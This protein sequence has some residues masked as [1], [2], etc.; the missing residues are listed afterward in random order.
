[1][2]IQKITS[3]DISLLMPLFEKYVVFYQ[4]EF[5]FQKYHDYLKTVIDNQEAFVF[6]A[7]DENRKAV[8]FVLNYIT[9]SSLLAN[10]IMILNDLFVDSEIRKNGI[11]EQLIEASKSFAMEKNIKNI[12]L[13]TAKDN[14]VAQ[15]LYDKMNF[16]R[17]EQFFTYDLAL[18]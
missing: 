3:E 18:N 16:V 2:R 6:L 12:R 13:R 1:M 8:G 9:F 5:H 14:V 4:K 11:G 10:K 15:G 7:F 17:D